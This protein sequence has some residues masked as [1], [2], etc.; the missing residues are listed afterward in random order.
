MNGVIQ[1]IY[2]E[3][4]AEFDKLAWESVGHSHKVNMNTTNVWSIRPFSK[5]QGHI[6]NKV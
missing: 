5:L 2:Y 6:N 4:F 1:I 3:L